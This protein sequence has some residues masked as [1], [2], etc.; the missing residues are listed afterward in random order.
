MTEINLILTQYHEI[1]HFI[2]YL[3][4]IAASIQIIYYIFFYTRVFWFKQRKAENQNTNEPVSIIIAAHNEAENLKRFLP[5]V[6][7][8]NY[9]TF[10][11]IV[12][13]DRSEDE[14]DTIIALFKKKYPHLKSSFISVN[15][16]ITYGKKLAV[17]I[18]IKAAKYNKILLTDA[19]CQ[20]IS[21]NWIQS[22]AKHF[23]SKDIIL[24]YGPYFD[25]KT[26]INKLI[27]FDTLFIAIQY[28][29]FAKAGI[30]YMGVGRN[31]AYKKDIFIKNKG[32]ASHA[33]I[34]SGDDDLFISEVSNTKNTIISIDPDSFVYSEPKKD[35]KSW[36]IQKSRH[37][38]TFNR[39][40]KIH[41]ILLP[42]EVIS[43]VIFY[44]LFF[45]LITNQYNNYFLI[46]IA[47]IRVLLF[48]STLSYSTYL[49]KEKNINPFIILFDLISPFINL[50]VYLRYSKFN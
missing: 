2:I 49:F 44:T 39:Y 18:G 23:S 26:F 19:D 4:Y 43:R 6:L 20:P 35:F 8:Q 12:I 30:P 22:M 36:A 7:E 34:K 33:H 16:K 47:S 15:S 25:K 3:F 17:T 48:I 46:S 21:R 27:R 10:E 38:T 37:F 11:V 40:K 32:L 50:F 41:K 9:P 5:S 29:S 14:T 45:L 42:L 1:E 13:N 31:L 28:F 24:G